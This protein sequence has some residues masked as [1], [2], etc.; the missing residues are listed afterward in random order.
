VNYYLQTSRGPRPALP[1]AS[2]ER[3][4]AAVAGK[5]NDTACYPMTGMAAG[6]KGRQASQL[7]HAVACHAMLSLL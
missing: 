4:G 2:L 1:Q 3:Q 6:R 5:I 7:S